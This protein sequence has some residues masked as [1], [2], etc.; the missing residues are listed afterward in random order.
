M[1]IKACMWFPCSSGLSLRCHMP[2]ETTQETTFRWAAGPVESPGVGAG[3][4]G[5]P[6]AI[7]KNCRQTPT[8]LKNCFPVLESEYLVNWLWQGPVTCPSPYHTGPTGS[9]TPCSALVNLMSPRGEFGR[10]HTVSET[11]VHLVSLTAAYFSP[12]FQFSDE[13]HPRWAYFGH[14]AW[15]ITRY[16]SEKSA[17]CRF[18]RSQFPRLPAMK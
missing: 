14:Q 18:R 1:S 10:L 17:S 6:T 15:F 16:V 12:N 8:L 4:G 2:P 9:W 5:K 13:E 3:A 7:Y 11:A